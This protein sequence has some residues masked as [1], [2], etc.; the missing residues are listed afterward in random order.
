MIHWNEGEERGIWM[1][2]RAWN[3]Y[4][5]QKLHILGRLGVVNY[6]RAMAL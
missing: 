5:H 6:G 2:L 4:K 3:E 1:I